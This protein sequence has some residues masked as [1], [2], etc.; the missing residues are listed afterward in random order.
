MPT[1]AKLDYYNCEVSNGRIKVQVDGL[2]DPDLV[3]IMS[4]IDRCEG[5]IYLDG[6]RYRY[7]NDYELYT[8]DELAYMELVV[9]QV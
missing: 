7:M 4:E 8:S 1:W 2:T 9:E 3:D 6:R 5:R